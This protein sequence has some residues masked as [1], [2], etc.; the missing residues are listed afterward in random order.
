MN[1]NQKQYKY[2]HNSKEMLLSFF[3]WSTL[4]TVLPFV[5]FAD[6]FCFLCFAF[7]P[8][9]ENRLQQESARFSDVIG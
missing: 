2:V 9:D 8:P 6:M 7:S 3:Q 4:P 5:L 1:E